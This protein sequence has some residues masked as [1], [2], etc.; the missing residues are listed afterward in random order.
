MEQPEPMINL[1]NNIMKTEYNIVYYQICFY[2]SILNI[3]LLINN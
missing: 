2:L 3:L 1:I